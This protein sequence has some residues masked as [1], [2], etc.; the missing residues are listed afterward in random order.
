MIWQTNASSDTLKN[1]SKDNAKMEHMNKWLHMGSWSH[2]GL[3]LGSG[4]RPEFESG[5][6]EHFGSGSKLGTGISKN[7]DKKTEKLGFVFQKMTDEK[8]NALLTQ[9]NTLTATITDP[10]LLSIINNIKALIQQNIGN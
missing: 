5:N 2:T 4:N 8:L 1:D 10:T 3:H 9:I 6:K 7:M